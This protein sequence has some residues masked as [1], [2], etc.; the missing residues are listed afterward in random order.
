MK[1]GR[2]ELELPVALAPMAGV[3]DMPFRL[4]CRRMGCGLTVSEMVSAKGLLY[5]NAKT[6]AMLRIGDGERPT[7]IQ[8]F[9]SVPRELARAARIAEESGADLIDFNMGCPVPK[10]VNNGEGAALM[11]QPQLAYAILAAMADAVTI[12]VIVKIRAGWNA[13]ARNAAEIAQ[14]AER[15]GAA[16]ITVHGRTR[17]QFYSGRAD[18]EIIKQVKQA[19]RIPVFGNGDLF[20]PEDAVSMLARTGCDGV[21]IGRGAEGNP[22]I[23]AGLRAALRG[24]TAPAAPATDAV[25]AMAKEHLRLLAAFKGEYIAVREM[26]RHIAAYLKGRPHAAEFRARFYQ[27]GTLAEFMALLEEY[28]DCARAFKAAQDFHRG[29]VV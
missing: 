27:V 22:W 2:V 6:R 21:A 29:E 18:W 3:T 14:A 25:L 9:G 16:A 4:L 12:P 7:A 11:R 1:I 5:N 13:A 24:E 20:T 28:G 26:R 10:I 8:L 17:E 23:F 19:V 15:A